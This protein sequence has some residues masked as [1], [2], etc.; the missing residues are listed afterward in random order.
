MKKYLVV[1]GILLSACSALKEMESVH[2]PTPVPGAVNTIVV[3]TAAA[4]STQTAISRSPTQTPSPASLASPS[5][6]AS[7]AVAVTATV[8]SSCPFSGPYYVRVKPFAVGSHNWEIYI[9]NYPTWQR[10]YDYPATLFL[11]Y[12][13]NSSAW[14][15]DTE[16]INLTGDWMNAMA[17][18]NGSGWNYLHN[19]SD[20][21]FFNGNKL[22]V[23]TF[24]GNVLLVTGRRYRRGACWDSISSFIYSDLYSAAALD[25]PHLPAYQLGLQTGMNYSTP[26]LVY[27]APNSD[28]NIYVPIISQHGDLWLGD[29]NVEAFPALPMDITVTAGVLNITSSPDSKNSTTVETVVTGAHLTLTDYS[30]TQRLTFGQV[31]DPATGMTGYVSLFKWTAYMKG[32]Y[33]T[34]WT[35]Q[36]LPVP[37]G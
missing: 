37:P 17:N 6:S 10:P 2:I 3:Q 4:A 1:L 23:D 28:G 24:P 8:G 16:Y 13:L 11:Q 20:G 21:T 19:A 29:S 35:M 33:T 26:N 15:T 25:L 5:P 32:A 31:T 9:P 34:T 30:P 7:P 27:P 12:I 14:T 22:G 18:L 36:T